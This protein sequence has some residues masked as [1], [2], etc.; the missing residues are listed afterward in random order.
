MFSSINLSDRLKA[1]VN[2]I[3][4]TG[5][6]LQQRAVGQNQHPPP[7]SQQSQASSARPASQSVNRTQTPTSSAGDKSASNVANSTSPTRNTGLGTAGYATSTSALAEGALSGLRKSFNFGRQSADGTRP[8]PISPRG[9]TSSIPN[10]AQ[11]LKDI[12]S[13]PNGPSRPNSPAKFLN[14]SLTNFQLGSDPTSSV[15][16]PRFKSPVS[17]L[18]SAL[19]VTLPPDPDDPAS[20]PLPP[21]PTIPNSPLTTSLSVPLTGFSDPLGAS[22]LLPPADVDERVPVLG[23]EEPTPVEEK[24]EGAAELQGDNVN[25]MEL[26]AGEE[27]GSPISPESAEVNE[28]STELNGLS[29]LE[30]A[31]KRYEGEL[32]SDMR[33]N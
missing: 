9:S 31:E 29:D 25:A 19:A 8:G 28:S 17:G 16:T 3:E 6:S 5:T 24:A 1:A 26:K 21:S 30:K 23:I 32:T 11:E 12:Y 14:P 2:Q 7:G 4:A 15:G 10:P 27:S 13:S 33:P 22:P 18:K 20:F